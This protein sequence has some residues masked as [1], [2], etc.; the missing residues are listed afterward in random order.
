[1]GRVRSLFFTWGAREPER[2]TPSRAEATTTRRASFR[3]WARVTLTSSPILAPMESRV[4]PSMR[5]NGVP[6]GTWSARSIRHTFATVVPTG[7]ATVTISPGETCNRT[8]ASELSSA[9][10][11]PSWR[12]VALATL[13]TTS[14]GVMASMY[15]PP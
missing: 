11:C 14:G 7:P 5:M 8:R 3:S 9:A 10:F 15:K 12:G 1:M 6:V 13:K 2:W 4:G